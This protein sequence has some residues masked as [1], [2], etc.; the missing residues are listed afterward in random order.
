MD[1][2][3]TPVTPGSCESIYTHMTYPGVGFSLCSATVHVCEEH[4]SCTAVYTHKFS[5]CFC[6]DV[7]IV[8]FMCSY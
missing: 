5:P 4:D 3:L 1:N 8:E 7:Y 6:S 2:P